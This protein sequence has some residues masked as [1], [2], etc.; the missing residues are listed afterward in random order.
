MLQRSPSYVVSLP[1]ED[2]IAKLAAPLACRRRRAYAIVR[3]KNV[4]V[5]MLVFQLS[6]RRPELVKRLIRRGVERQLPAGYDVDT[7]FK[8]RY[9]PWDQ[10]L[11]LVP[12][13]D[14]FEAIQRRARVGRHRPH[15][16]VHRAGS[17]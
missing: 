16:D 10:R 3:W 12:D 14:L 8:P 7:H 6:R 17:G 5:T 2:P 13:G 1:A 15:R 11:C 9:N 4:L